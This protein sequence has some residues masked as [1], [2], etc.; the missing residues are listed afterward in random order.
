[1]KQAARY[2]VLAAAFFAACGFSKETTTT[3]NYSTSIPSDVD[4]YGQP[5]GERKAQDKLPQAHDAIWQTFAKTKIKVDEKKGLYS[6]V[7]TD[8]VKA[9]V[10]KEITISGF[11]LPL[12]AS[13]KFKHFILSKRTPTCFFC[14]PGQPNEIVDVWTDKSTDWKE[15]LIK[16]TGTF[17]LMNDPQLGMFFKLNKAK[18]DKA[19]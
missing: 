18:I 13:E 16:V 5:K 4:Q 1:M 8:D 12:E 19:K 17:E 6:A 2:I 3:L 9:M 14:P 15:E 7:Y 10:G 11:M